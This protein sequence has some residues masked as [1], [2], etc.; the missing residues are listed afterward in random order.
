MS[1][2]PR[3]AALPEQEAVAMEQCPHCSRSF[4]AGRLEKHMPV[5][6]RAQQQKKAREQQKAAAKS[7]KA[8]EEKKE[9]DNSLAKYHKWKNHS[10]N[11]RG[12]MEYNRKLAEAQKAGID[13]ATLPPPPEAAADDRVSCP[14]CKRKFAPLAAERHIPL[15]NANPNKR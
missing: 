8:E 7:D 1:G 10:A 13:I 12:A 5:C 3:D 14:H 15:C 11:L 2:T 9:G 4:A 6:Q